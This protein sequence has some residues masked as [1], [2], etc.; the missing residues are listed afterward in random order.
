MRCFRTFEF[1]STPNRS[2]CHDFGKDIISGLVRDGR[3]S[4]F[5]F[6]ETRRHLGSYW[7]DVGTVEAYYRA[8]MELLMTG[9]LDPYDDAEWPLYSFDEQPR[10][11]RLF[12]CAGALEDE[13]VYIAGGVEIGYD[14]RK[15]REYGVVTES[16]IVVIAA[17]TRIEKPEK[18]LSSVFEVDH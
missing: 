12:A 16:G 11:K 6:T 5:N 2:L 17:N 15:D 4:V 14:I 9:T 3:I 18:S 10:P 7:R 13:N 8:N 1:W